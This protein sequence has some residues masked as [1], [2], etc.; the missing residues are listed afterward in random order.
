MTLLQLSKSRRH[1]TE[2]VLDPH[3]M[4]IYVLLSILLALLQA[5]IR[6]FLRTFLKRPAHFLSRK[7]FQIFSAP[8]VDLPLV[9]PGERNDYCEVL[10]RGSRLVT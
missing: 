6:D 3:I 7:T 10:A 4:I 2:I 9:K 8:E 1:I 5:V